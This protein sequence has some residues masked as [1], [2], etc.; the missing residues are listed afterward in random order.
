MATTAAQGDLEAAAEAVE[1]AAAVAEAEEMT[2][3]VA[4]GLEAE[5]MAACAAA[6]AQGDLGAA[7]EAMVVDYLISK[8]LGRHQ[9]GE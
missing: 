2:A 8:S 7:A 4:E 3:T 5:E 1:M 6:A 9:N